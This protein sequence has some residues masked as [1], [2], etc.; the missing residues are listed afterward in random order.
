MKQPP[1]SQIE[2]NSRLI[3]FLTLLLL[4]L[5]LLL[6]Y[7][8]WVI[9]L[10]GLGG[11]WWLGYRWV[12]WL[13]SGLQLSREM[14]FGWTQV[15]DRIEERFTLKNSGWAP[16]LWVEVRDHSTMPGY[17]VSM[18]TGVGMHNT[19]KWRKRGMCTQRGLFTLGPT[20]LRSGDPFGLYTLTIHYPTTSTIMVSPPIVPLPS[21][22]VAAGGQKDGGRP[23]PFASRHT[24]NSAGSRPYLPGDE[25]RW[26]H[27][28]VSA[29]KGSLHVRLFDDAPVGDWWI[30]L[31]LNQQ[32]QVG[33]G[34]SST[35][36]H[37]IILAA[38]LADRGL[39]EG[40][41]V[42]LA[43]ATGGENQDAIWLPPRSGESHRLAI[44]QALALAELGELSLADFLTRSRSTFSREASVIVITPACEGQWL[45][46]LL[47]LRRR[48][49]IPTVLLLDANSFGAAKV[50][51]G[52][53]ANTEACQQQLS[54][55]GIISH[56]IPRDLLDRPEARPGQ[57]GAWEWIVSG[58]GRAFAK[59]KP[60]DLTWKRL[61]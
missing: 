45:E 22:E 51:L 35:A 41:S 21:I 20:E 52:A 49:T 2:L 3:P 60:K 30:I 50:N 31:D 57:Q 56:I 18:V 34:S 46:N 47:L 15:G 58:T 5:Q 32:V 23:R 37:A 48:G 14:R 39:R 10:V 11:I 28:R 25:K 8:G 7:R 1:I 38:S 9:G 55:L 4:L 19:N 42:G 27:W 16:G 17:E 40:R 24:L 26:I 44:L 29:H 33:E 59:Q 12:Q 53:E 43:A 61:F 13:A 6:P 54:Q 36:E